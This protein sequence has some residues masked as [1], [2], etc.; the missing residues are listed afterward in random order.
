M[1]T[2][3]KIQTFSILTIIIASLTL[4]IIPVYAENLIRIPAGSSAPGCEE[5]NK[6]YIPYE[7]KIVNGS[8]ITWSNDDHVAYTITSGTVKE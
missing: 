1:Q 8:K 6:C 4:V 7:T 2:V 5:K 3:T